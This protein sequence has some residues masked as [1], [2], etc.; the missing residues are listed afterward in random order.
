MTQLEQVS[1]IHSFLR[2]IF[3]EGDLIE[4]RG[5]KSDYDGTLSVLTDDLHLAARTASSMEK[6]GSDV[7][8]TL[9]PISRE[10]GLLTRVTRN[11]PSRH[12]GYGST[13]GD[14]DT[15]S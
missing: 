7:Y 8:Y 14:K 6:R 3:T 15:A 4:V 2:V 5:L 13:T 9:N 12:V 11:A 1:A 10:S